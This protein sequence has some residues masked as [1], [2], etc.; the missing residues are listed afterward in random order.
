MARNQETRSTKPL[1]RFLIKKRVV[2]S[3]IGNEHSMSLR[4]VDLPPHW[5]AC[6]CVRDFPASDVD[7][8]INQ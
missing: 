8:F 3:A 1:A 2:R 4:K 7:V 5:F 6:A